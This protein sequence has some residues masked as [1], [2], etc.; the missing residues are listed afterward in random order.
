MPTQGGLLDG[1]FPKN[2]PI[3]NEGNS[4]RITG[5]LP[6]HVAVAN[7]LTSMYEFLTTLPDVEAMH[8]AWVHYSTVSYQLVWHY[9]I[10]Y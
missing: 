9:I 7:G 6:I 10:V 8:A 4:C 1:V 5:F 3:N 2:D